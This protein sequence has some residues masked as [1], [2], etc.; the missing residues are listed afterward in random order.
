M[1]SIL[2]AACFDANG[3]VFEPLFGE[4]DAILSDALNHASI[5]DGIRLSKAKRFRFTN[6][7]M[8]DLETQLKA[9]REGG[10][11]RIVIVTDG[12]LLDGSLFRQAG[13]DPRIGG[14]P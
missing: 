9:A 6:G 10:A 7:D 12:V 1:T 14:S 2:F 8:N 5:I 13:R 11:R 3:A 4:Q